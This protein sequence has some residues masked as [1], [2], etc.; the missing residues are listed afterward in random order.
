MSGVYGQ[1]K[2]VS[3]GG[4]HRGVSQ[5]AYNG[6]T[7]YNILE[8]ITISSPGDTSD[9]GDLNSVIRWPGSCDN[10]TNDRGCFMGGFSYTNVIDYITVSSAG[11]AT[12][13]GDLLTSGRCQSAGTSNDTNE[14]GVIM[15]G[16]DNDVVGGECNII[17]YITINSLG[18]S[19][20]FGDCSDLWNNGGAFSNGTNE[21][22][23]LVVGRRWSGHVQNV[24]EYITINSLGD[25]TD[26]GDLTAK[27]KD[28]D[29]TSNKT[30]DRGVRTGGVDGDKVTEVNIIDY[31]TISSTGDATDFGD[32]VTEQRNAAATSNA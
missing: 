4:T 25:T 13:F 17:E 14:R 2:A 1:G 6:S 7:T 31:I 8:Y 27:A 22:G 26:F 12:D 15:S 23:V 5:A 16:S 11:D 3:N 21:R 18:N 10:G 28:L 19:T 30:T 20:D 9:F 29:A 32:L 24:I